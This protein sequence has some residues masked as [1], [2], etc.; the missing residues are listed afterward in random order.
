M[1]VLF[2]VHA[3]TE[4]CTIVQK[5]ECGLCSAASR[6]NAH[7]HECKLPTIKV[8][9]R[10]CFGW[11][12]LFCFVNERNN[13]QRPGRGAVVSFIKQQTTGLEVTWNMIVNSCSTCIVNAFFPLLPVFLLVWTNPDGVHKCLRRWLSLDCSTEWG[14]RGVREECATL[15]V[16]GGVVVGASLDSLSLSAPREDHNCGKP[17]RTH[18]D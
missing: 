5:R 17:Q 12:A 7:G 4:S 3:L 16:K 10:L 13:G 18:L 9:E 14:G 11:V 2:L 6:P 1:S 8:L 15:A